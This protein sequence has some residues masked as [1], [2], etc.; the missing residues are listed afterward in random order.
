VVL[1]EEVMPKT[2]LIE[3]M[4]KAGAPKTW[5][6]EV[7]KFARELKEAKDKAN[8]YLG[9]IDELARQ[10]IKHCPECREEMEEWSGGSVGNVD[11]KKWYW[12]YLRCTDCKIR[13][14]YERSQEL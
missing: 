4:E 14:K 5:I 12:A 2:P 13:V 8:E 1:E 9:V 3:R 10:V 6:L 7:L 11:G